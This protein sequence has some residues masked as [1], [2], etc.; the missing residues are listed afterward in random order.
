MLSFLIFQADELEEGE[1]AVSGDSPMNQQ[2][3]G[4]WNQ[5]RDEGED[6]QVLQPKI[7]RKRSIRLRPQHARAEEKPSDKLSLR[8][9][10]PSQLPVLVDNKYKTQ[11]SD[12]RAHKVLGDTSLMKPDKTDSSIK[13]KRNLPSRRNTANVQST[14]K[15]G[16][17]NHAP[18]LPDDATE[19]FRET[20]ES[21]VV[22]GPKTSGSKMPEVIQRKVCCFDN[23]YFCANRSCYFRLF[24]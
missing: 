12:D 10:D 21:K 14:L 16:R 5:D 17:V 9:S 24:C 20:L 3:S 22:K 4:S 6:E 18:A 7:K 11:A 13:N 19:H 1:I 8:R 15:S 23:L 2:Q